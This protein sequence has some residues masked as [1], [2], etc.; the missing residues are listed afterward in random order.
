MSA[1]IM[2]CLEETLERSVKL[3]DAIHDLLSDAEYDTDVAT[4]EGYS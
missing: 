4:C 1:S 2:S 3:D